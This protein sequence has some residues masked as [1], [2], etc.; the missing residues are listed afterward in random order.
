[1]RYVYVSIGLES[2]DQNWETQVFRVCHRN[3][4]VDAKLANQVQRIQ[5]MWLIFPEL[6]AV[7]AQEGSQVTAGVLRGGD[8]LYT[9]IQLSKRCKI[10]FAM[11][12]PLVYKSIWNHRQPKL[13]SKKICVNL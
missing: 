6:P 5:L 13:T 3:S 4:S 10:F 7:G 2:P 11:K 9:L 1:M 8:N 12:W